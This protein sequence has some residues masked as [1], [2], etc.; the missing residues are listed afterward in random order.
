MSKTDVTVLIYD[1]DD[2][3]SLHCVVWVYRV[4][5][6]VCSSCFSV[7]MCVKVTA[8]RVILDVRGK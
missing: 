6:G 3:D 2:D 1:D 8:F 4:W 7:S 5:R